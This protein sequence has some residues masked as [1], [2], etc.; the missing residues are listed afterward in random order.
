[1]LQWLVEKSDCMFV[2][3]RDDYVCGVASEEMVY[4]V[5]TNIHHVE[6]WGSISENVGRGD[7]PGYGSI[8]ESLPPDGNA[9]NTEYY[10][11]VV[12]Y[13]KQCQSSIDWKFENVFHFSDLGGIDMFMSVLILKHISPISK[14][15]TK[16]RRTTSSQRVEG[17]FRMISTGKGTLI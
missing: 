14:A 2:G 13:G 1:M 11:K 12:G 17:T 10:K 8:A 6:H 15:S 9:K 16:T 4:S 3:L 7:H 5:D